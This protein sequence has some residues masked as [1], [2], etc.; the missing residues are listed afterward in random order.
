MALIGI[1]NIRKNTS[2]DV[3]KATFLIYEVRTLTD[4]SYRM[5][6]GIRW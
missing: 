6:D 4:P 3:R 2:L 5:L 1:P